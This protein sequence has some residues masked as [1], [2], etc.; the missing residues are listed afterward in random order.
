MLAEKMGV[1]VATC[2]ERQCTIA[3]R[4]TSDL[5]GTYNAEYKKGLAEYAGPQC[6][7]AA[8]G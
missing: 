7:P 5:I 1:D 4:M 3:L 8:P 6:Y 2:T